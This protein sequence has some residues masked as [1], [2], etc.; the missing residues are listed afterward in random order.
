MAATPVELQAGLTIGERLRRLRR[1][2]GW[3]QS[4]VVEGLATRGVRIGN[5]LVSRWENDTRQPD[6]VQI[7]ALAE[8]FDVQT[9][10]LGATPELYPELAMLKEAATRRYLAGQRDR[11]SVLTV[12]PGGRRATDPPHASQAVLVR[13]L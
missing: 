3:E 5:T 4:Q 8:V 2:R 11:R 7:L 13:S 12:L 6:A 10:D 1:G 9:R